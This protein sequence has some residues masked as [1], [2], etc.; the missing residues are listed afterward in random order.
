MMNVTTKQ[1]ISLLLLTV[2]LAV[3]LALLPEYPT[4]SVQNQT[5]SKLASQGSK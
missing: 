1:L 4:D 2:T 5:V 3:L